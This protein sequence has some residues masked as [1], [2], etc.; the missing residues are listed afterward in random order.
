M[1][2][3]RT[4]AGLASIFGALELRVLEAVWRRGVDVAV[5]D[6]MSDFPQAA[7]TTVMTTMERLYRKGVLARHKQGR[8]HVY[9]ALA[10]RDEL[11]S[12]LVTHALTPLLGAGRAA[13]LL[14][15]FVEEVSRHDARLLDELERLVRDKRRE[16]DR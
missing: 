15:S 3:P 2:P 12:S 5:R 7:Y 6:L 1:V 4:P 14:S 9:S 8:A 16:R 11:E 13:P 10:T